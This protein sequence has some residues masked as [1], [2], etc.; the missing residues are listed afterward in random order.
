MKIDIFWGDLTDISAKKEALAVT[1]QYHVLKVGTEGMLNLCSITSNP[2]ASQ[3]VMQYHEQ[4]ISI[5]A[6]RPQEC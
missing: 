4:T 6:N 1:T 2:S 5:Q 3:E